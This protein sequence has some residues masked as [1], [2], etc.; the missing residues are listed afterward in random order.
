AKSQLRVGQATCGNGRDGLYRVIVSNSCGSVTSDAARVTFV[1]GTQITEQPRDVTVCPETSSS[2]FSV[3]ISNSADL[4]SQWEIASSAAPTEFAPLSD[5][6]NVLPDGRTM[7][8]FGSTGQ[9]LGFTVGA[10]ATP[11]SYIVRC[12]FISPCGGA[13][14]TTATITV[15]EQPAILAQPQPVTTCAAGPAE[16]SVT[17]DGVGPFTYLWQWE[18]VEAPGLWLNMN[19]G[20]NTDFSGLARFA[21]T[22]A[23]AGT[24][25]V[26]REALPDGS[27]AV[28]SAVR[29]VVTDGCST[30]TQPAALTV[31]PADFNCENGVDGDDVI[32]FFGLWDAGDPAADFDGQNGVDG[33]DVIAFFG[34]WDSGC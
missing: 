29:C 3:A 26:A 11:T 19:E 31:C 16:F 2:V 15:T 8:V 1:Q 27:L 33:D 17:P 34:R 24:L 4:T 20:T 18:P 5:G 21:A 25:S 6:L 28:I 7:E 14:S 13:T 22:G 10:F 12:Q 23:E 9:Y 30:R 32:A